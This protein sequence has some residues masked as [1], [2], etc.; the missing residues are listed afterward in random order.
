MV[1][2]FYR[3]VEWLWKIS[4]ERDYI[5]LDN[6]INFERIEFDKVYWRVDRDISKDCQYGFIGRIKKNKVFRVLFIM[7]E[8]TVESEDE[9]E[10]YDNENRL[11]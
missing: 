4:E 3:H 10:D 1:F 5:Y 8:N 2:D 11:A 7:E 6:E 9:Q